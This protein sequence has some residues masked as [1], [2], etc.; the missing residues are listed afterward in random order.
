[1]TFNFYNI[2]AV[3]IGGFLGAIL[4]F[5]ISTEVIKIFPNSIPMSTLFVNLTGSFLM[6]VMVSIFLHFTPSEILKGFL[7]IGFLGALTTYSTFAI[8]SYNL[9]NNNF[10]YGILNI[11]LNAIG[12]IV[13]VAIGYKTALRIIF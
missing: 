3:G 4:R 10:Y 11:L 12:S 5:Y 9:L 13:F 7:T 2:L 8:E 1:M 6:G